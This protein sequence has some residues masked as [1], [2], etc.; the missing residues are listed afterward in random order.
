MR[1]F[2]PFVMLLV[3]MAGG[4]EQASEW[5]AQI[6]QAGL[7][8]F[9]QL[10]LSSDTL[11]VAERRARE[12]QLVYNDGSPNPV[13]LA[14]LVLVLDIA[15]AIPAPR[16]PP[17]R[18]EPLV[19]T[20]PAEA[21]GLLAPGGRIEI[22]ISDVIREA[23]ETLHIGAPYWNRKGFEILGEALRPAI[24]ERMVSCDFY[25]HLHQNYTDS[26]LP[27]WLRSLG[28]PQNVRLWWYQGPAES[29]MHAKFCVADGRI[30]YIGTANLTS[31]AL[32]QHVEVGIRLLPS[33]CQDLV[34]MLAGLK[35]QRLFELHTA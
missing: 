29:L 28:A 9:R 26:W 35:E 10:G 27:S 6:Q 22:L 15:S 18:T 7:D 23:T 1:N 8:A 16:Q 25:A 13:Q 20:V 31:K 14:Q 34:T 19:F 4:Y 11:R 33:Q 3:D 32:Q 30:G 17:T 12:L 5:I 24:E 21:E 2:V